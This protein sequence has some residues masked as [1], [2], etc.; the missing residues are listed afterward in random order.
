M[1]KPILS[2]LAALT[3]LTAAPAAAKELSVTVSFGD[4]DL[5]TRAGKVTLNKRIEAAV[6]KVC[7]PLER[8]DLW[9]TWAAEECRAL[10][11]ADAMEQLAAIDPPADVALAASAAN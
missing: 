8:R 11:L 10:T 4:L 6:D 3:V 2:V 7:S 9:G 5:T 1:R